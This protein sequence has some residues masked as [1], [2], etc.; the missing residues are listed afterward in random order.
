MEK[1]PDRLRAYGK[2]IQK[3]QHI[4]VLIDEDRDDCHSLKER[5]ENAA[6]DAGL[7]TRTSPGPAGGFQVTNRLAI[8]ELEA[9]AD[10][11][12]KKKAHGRRLTGSPG[13]LHQPKL[14]L[15]LV[16]RAIRSAR[17]RGGRMIWIRVLRTMR[18]TAHATPR[19][20]SPL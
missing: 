3:G 16:D 20:G 13:A 10:E 7:T 5:L 11:D 2:S 4:V 9:K 1:L 8:E 15:L 6:R 17:T 12:L 18:S 14:H 19:D